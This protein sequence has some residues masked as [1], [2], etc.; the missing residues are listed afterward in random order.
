MALLAVSFAERPADRARLL[1][2]RPA[3][4]VV[5]LARV[6]ALLLLP[7]LRE[8]PA[9]LRELPPLRERLE[10]LWAADA[11][12]PFL[13]EDLRALEP[14]DRPLVARELD[15]PDESDDPFEDDRPRDEARF[16]DPR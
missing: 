9:L 4:A 16:E 14:E 3:P 12:A 7:P 15:D 1:A 2:E 13:A 6:D 10:L 8:L 5:R 11:E